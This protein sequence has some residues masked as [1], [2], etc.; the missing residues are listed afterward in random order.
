MARERNPKHLVPYVVTCAVPAAF[1]LVAAVLR[2]HRD[3]WVGTSVL[4][5]MSVA[6]GYFSSQLRRSVGVVTLSSIVVL[7]AYPLVGPAGAIVVSAAPLFFIDGYELVQRVFNAACSVVPSLFGA[8]AYGALHGPSVDGVNAHWKLALLA[9]VVTDVVRFGVNQLMFMPLAA[10][11]AGGGLRK[12]LHEMQR[13]LWRTILPSHLGYGPLGLLLAVI[14]RAGLGPVAVVVVMVPLVSAHMAFARAAEEEEARS[15]ALKTLIRAVETKDPYTRGHSERV[16]DGVTRLGSTVGLTGAR[17][18]TLRFAGLLHDVGKLGVPTR[19]L[20]KSGSLTDQEF[21]QIRSHPLQGFDV[22]AGIDF[23]DEARTAILHHHERVDGRG[24]PTG[25]AGAAIPELARMISV[26]DAFDSMTSS[27]TYHQPRSVPEALAELRRCAGSHFDDDYVDAFC[28][29]VDTQG[30][31][32][33]GGVGGLSV[34]VGKPEPS[35]VRFGAREPDSM[36]APVPASSG[37]RPYDHDD[38][39]APPPI[40]SPGQDP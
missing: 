21:A 1:L 2:V 16:S 33:T 40:D 31:E 10:M 18:L 19:V 13:D 14:W 34:M 5:V 36:P 22:V 12:Q 37:S 9:C 6:V 15:D 29:T 4:L 23:L 11:F 35:D 17:L 28:R 3:Q 39:T 8:L 38:P 7:A 30:W 25:L 24:Y 32:S 26:V 20:T 27:R